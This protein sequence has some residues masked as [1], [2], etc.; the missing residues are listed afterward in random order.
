MLPVVV[1]DA[2]GDAAGLGRATHT[3]TPPRGLPRRGNTPVP[4]GSPWHS[5]NPPLQS[6]C[7][8]WV[9]KK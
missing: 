3:P 7:D 9:T 2:V 4:T 5:I 8:A 6:H 1:G